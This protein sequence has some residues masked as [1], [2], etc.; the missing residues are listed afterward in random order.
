MIKILDSDW[1]LRPGSDHPPDLPD[2][3]CETPFS[4]PDDVHSALLAAG[5]IDDPYFRDNELAVDWVNRCDWIIER[6]LSLIHI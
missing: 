4:A 3:I 1:T 5:H 6:N 2:K